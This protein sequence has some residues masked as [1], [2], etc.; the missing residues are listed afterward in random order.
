MEQ[1]NSG[2]NEGNGLPRRRSAMRWLK[3][4]MPPGLKKALKVLYRPGNV[5]VL[6]FKPSYCEDGLATVH[7]CGFVDDPLFSAAYAKG[8]ATGSWDGIRWR[9]HVYTWL[10]SQAFRLDGDFVECGVNRGGYARMVF[11]YLPFARSS[12]RF[13][14]LDTFNGF[15]LD[16]LSKEEIA[17]GIPDVYNY[18]ECFADVRRTFADFP[19]AILV[20]GRIPNTLADVPTRKVAFLSIDMNCA[21]PE[22]AAAE[23]FWD[24]IVSGGLILLDDYGHPRHIEQ[25]IAF[26]EFAERHG[27]KILHLPTEQGLMMRP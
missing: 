10:A 9:A 13:Y 23:F 18:G 25:K 14:L 22:I 2:R 19:N 3:D 16:L 15:S 21:A 20:R 12:K 4:R 17:R 11:E 8:V 7:S 5:V 27:V 1:L 24:K 6:P 26:D